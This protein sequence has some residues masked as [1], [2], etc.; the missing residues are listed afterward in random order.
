[1][2]SPNALAKRQ[3]KQHDMIINNQTQI[4]EMLGDLSNRVNALE[5]RLPEKKKR[6]RP[7]SEPTI[8]EKATDQPETPSEEPTTE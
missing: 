6:G 7:K 4:I 5:S 8:A 1:M 3:K 2:P